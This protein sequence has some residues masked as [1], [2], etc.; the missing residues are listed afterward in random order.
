M[1]DV[2]LG[3]RLRG[4]GAGGQGR[5]GLR[6]QTQDDLGKQIGEVRLESDR[7]GDLPG[8]VT[9]PLL[10]DRCHHFVGAVLQE[11]GEEQVSGL[12]EGQVLLVLHLATGQEPG[13]L[14]VQQGRGHD[15]EFGGLVQIPLRALCA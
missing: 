15:E 10:E 11:P 2:D 4:Q 8:G 9:H 12:Q 14:E 6:P 1:A 7:A 13:G 3:L 5:E